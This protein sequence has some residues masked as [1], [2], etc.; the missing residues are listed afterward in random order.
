MGD[1]YPLSDRAAHRVP[2][3]YDARVETFDQAAH[4]VQICRR[5]VNS[6]LGPLAAAVAAKIQRE[7]A[8]VRRQQ[9][10][11]AVPPMHMGGA[12]VQQN[13]SVFVGIAAPVQIVK[14][15]SL[16]FDEPMGRLRE[17]GSRLLLCHSEDS[18][19]RP[20]LRIDFQARSGRANNRKEPNRKEKRQMALRLENKNALT[21]CA[22]SGIG[23]ATA[24]RFAEEGANVFVA[25]RHL[26]AAEENA[27]SVQKLGRKAI[28][29]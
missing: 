12:A 18:M 21:P 29:I 28:A 2:D 11:D 7:H 4:V 9:G 19:R 24:V 5:A 6:R 23:R 13:E 27:A 25:D 1:G 15:E 17:D 14:L 26:A 8:P 16:N 20:N 22:A 3:Q 10:S